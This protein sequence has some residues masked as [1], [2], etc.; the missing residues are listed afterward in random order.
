MMKGLLAALIAA[1][2]LSLFTPVALRTAGDDWPGGNLGTHVMQL[3]G[4]D[5]P[6]GN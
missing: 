1:V 4:D 3:A 2:V 6:G 5:W